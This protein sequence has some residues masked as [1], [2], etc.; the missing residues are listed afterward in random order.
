MTP[1][2]LWSGLLAALTWVVRNQDTEGST[3]SADEGCAQRPDFT[4]CTLSD[5]AP[6]TGRWLGTCRLCGFSFLP[7][8]ATAHL[9]NCHPG[10]GVE[11]LD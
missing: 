11:A 3:P 2:R 10:L 7:E 9:T 1:Y 6:R 5:P 4:I 8:Y